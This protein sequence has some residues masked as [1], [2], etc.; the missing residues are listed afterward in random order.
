MFRLGNKKQ[1]PAAGTEKYKNKRPPQAPKT[2]NKFDFGIP[3]PRGMM[4]MTMMMQE[5]DAG[6]GGCSGWVQGLDAGGGCRSWMQEEDAGGRCRGVDAAGG[7][8]GWMQ[9]VDA[10]G[11]CRVWMQGV[12]RI[13]P[14]WLR[15]WGTVG[16]KSAPI[17]ARAFFSETPPSGGGPRGGTRGQTGARPEAGTPGGGSRGGGRE[18]GHRQRLEAGT[19]GGGEEEDEE[20]EEKEEARKKKQNLHTG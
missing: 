5:V 11:G 14:G 7:C 3:S 13:P 20:E 8:R 6:R 1:E 2:L 9:E 10:G 17:G 18:R 16:P 15:A 19:P 4:M 12:F